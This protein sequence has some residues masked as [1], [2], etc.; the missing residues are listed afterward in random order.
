MELDYDQFKSLI[1][2]HPDRNKLIRIL[3]LIDNSASPATTGPIIRKQVRIAPAS[4]ERMLYFLTGIGAVVAQPVGRAQAYAL[5][6]NYSG[7]LLDDLK[8]GDENA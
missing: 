6:A 2:D 1:L 4:L 7:H 8:G 3:T 5:T